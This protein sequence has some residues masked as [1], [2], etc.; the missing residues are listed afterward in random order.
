MLLDV[1]WF[2]SRCLGLVI[3]VLGCLF[4]I[5]FIG[6]IA[7]WMWVLRPRRRPDM[8][9]EWFCTHSGWTKQE[10]ANRGH[11]THDGPCPMDLREAGE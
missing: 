8:F 5:A 9:R 4:A 6:G 7:S 1:I 3:L 2:T 11:C 10:I